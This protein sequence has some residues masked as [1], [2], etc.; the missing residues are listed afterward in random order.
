VKS[1][2]LPGADP[3][4]KDVFVEIDYVGDTRLSTADR[5]RI[6]R[7]FD[8][9]PVENPGGES[10]IALHLVRDERL[11]ATGVLDEETFQRYQVERFDNSC[12][13]YH[14]A[15]LTPSGTDVTDAE[16]GR[17][18]TRGGAVLGGSVFISNGDGFVFMHEL[19]H[20]LGLDHGPEGAS[21]SEYPSMMNYAVP[22]QGPSYY[23]F[24]DGGNSLNDRDDWEFLEEKMYGAGSDGLVDPFVTRGSCG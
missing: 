7:L 18:V 20:V 15:V 2:R 3:L 11:P 8:E 23:G 13:G 17:D 22:R 6:V 10:G 14:Y 19:G 9:A 4:R 5:E 1:D 12:V 24:S 21:Y 16:D